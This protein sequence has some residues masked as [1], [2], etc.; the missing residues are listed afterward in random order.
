MVEVNYLLIVSAVFFSIASPG[1]ATISI[2]STSAN[3]GKVHGSVLAYG[4]A[5][6]GFI[7]SCAAAFGLSSIMYTNAWLF[8][9]LRYVGAGYLLYLAFKSTCSACSKKDI[10][11]SLVPKSSLRATYFKGVALQLTNPKVILSFASIY[12]ILLPS[13]TSPKEL[14][15]VII[16]ISV[17]ANVLFQVYAY[18]FSTTKVRVKYFLL[19]RYFESIFALFFGFAGFKILTTKLE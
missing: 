6:G 13:D 1:P 8:D 14:V 3:H 11:M 9:L 5:T 16:S 10:Q 15:L 17:M 2:A 7:W 18:L 12:A 4:I 19:R